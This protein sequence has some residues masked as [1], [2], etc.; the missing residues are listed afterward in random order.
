M[1]RLIEA[2]ALTV[3]MIG[4]AIGVSSCERHKEELRL[5]HERGRELHKKVLDGIRERHQKVMDKVH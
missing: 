2:M 5:E 1:T 3:L 4:V